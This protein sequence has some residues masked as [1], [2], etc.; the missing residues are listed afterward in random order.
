M[1]VW[2]TFFALT[3]ACVTLVGHADGVANP[4]EA[5]SL[6]ALYGQYL[7]STNATRR[8]D[9]KILLQRHLD[10]DPSGLLSISGLNIPDICSGGDIDLDSGLDTKKMLRRANQRIV[11]IKTAVVK[12]EPK[13]AC[14]TALEKFKACVVSQGC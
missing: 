11:K 14:L 13:R 4:A 12:P 10:T 8:E 7:K 1:P 9:L 2:R 3:I 6:E 5:V